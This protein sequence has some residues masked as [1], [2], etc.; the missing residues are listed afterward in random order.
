M[1]EGAEIFCVVPLFCFCL[2]V[3]IVY[4]LCT[5]WCMASFLIVNNIFL[6]TYKK[7]LMR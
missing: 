4:V 7:K 3:P 2:V 5:P 1:R 6:L